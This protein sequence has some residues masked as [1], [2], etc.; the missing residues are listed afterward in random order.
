MII[1][2]IIIMIIKN[3]R[4]IDFFKNGAGSSYWVSYNWRHT[5]VCVCVCVCVCVFTLALALKE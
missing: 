2:I 3:L 5:T 1:M 4:H